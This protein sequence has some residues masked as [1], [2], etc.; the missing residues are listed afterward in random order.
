MSSNENLSKAVL[1]YA[2]AHNFYFAFMHSD[3]RY[4]LAQGYNNPK[5]TQ[6]VSAAVSETNPAKRVKLYQ[7]LQQLAYEDAMQI[8]TVH[9][10]GMWAMRQNVKGFE[11]NP[12]YMGLY[13][14]PMYK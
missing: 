14:Y 4:A 12:V 11:D 5:A 13:F 2:D 3:G 6:L 8:Y 9:P 7:Q 10:T 1:D